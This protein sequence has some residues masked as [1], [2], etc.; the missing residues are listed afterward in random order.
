MQ[1]SKLLITSSGVGPNIFLRI[2][3]DTYDLHS[4][5]KVWGRIFKFIKGTGKIAVLYIISTFGILKTLRD[6]NPTILEDV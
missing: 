3:P 1:Y 2:C 4:S 5:I 6:D